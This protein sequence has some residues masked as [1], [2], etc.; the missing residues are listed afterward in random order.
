[1]SPSRPF[2]TTPSGEFDTGQLL[3]EAIPLAKLVALVGAVALTPQ[4]LH[5]LAIE[6]LSITPALGIVFTLATQFVLAVGT[7]LVLIY[8]VVRANQLTDQ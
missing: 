1:M 4:L 2:F 7:G 3:Y 5:W 8:V 6:L